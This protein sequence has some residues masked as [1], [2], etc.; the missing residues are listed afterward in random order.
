MD[1]LQFLLFIAHDGHTTVVVVV[2]VVAYVYLSVGHLYISGV[3]AADAGTYVCE[4]DIQLSSSS[5]QTT[6]DVDPSVVEPL[7]ATS[8]LHVVSESLDV[9]VS[10]R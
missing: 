10:P 1:K 3:T 8:T 9:L 5:Q 2:V 6:V 4:T 7:R